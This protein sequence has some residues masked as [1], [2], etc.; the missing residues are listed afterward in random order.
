MG[1]GVV[2]LD[3][4]VVFQSVST[5]VSQLLDWLGQQK[6]FSEGICQLVFLYRIV[7]HYPSGS[8]LWRCIETG[9]LASMLPSHIHTAGQMFVYVYFFVYNQSK[10]QS[11]QLKF[12][13]HLLYLTHVLYIQTKLV[14]TEHWSSYSRADMK[15]LWLTQLNSV[16]SCIVVYKLLASSQLWQESHKTWKF[17]KSLM[18]HHTWRVWLIWTGGSCHAIL[19]N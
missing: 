11:Q 7:K 1:L 6:R 9:L 14:M 10:K 2:P 17:I 8:W 5:R 12:F 13:P 18:G 3:L 15:N 4:T 19:L 16:Q